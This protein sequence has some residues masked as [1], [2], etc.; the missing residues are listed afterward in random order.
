L[1]G[2]VPE[3]VMEPLHAGA[4]LAR[5]VALH[6]AKLLLQSAEA[7][8]TARPLGPV[9]ALAPL[10]FLGA[11]AG[12]GLQRGQPLLQRPQAGRQAF[13]HAPEVRARGL[14]RRR[15]SRLVPLQLE[16]RV[17]EGAL[18]GGGAIGGGLG[19]A[20]QRTE[21][22]VRPPPGAKPLPEAHVGRATRA[23]TERAWVT[24]VRT[25]EATVPTSRGPTAV[26]VGRSSTRPRTRSVTG[27]RPPASGSRE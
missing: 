26:P 23:S 2:V 13:P 12:L 8:V 17:G 4:Q 19:A 11:P 25:I 5:E 18:D 3:H 7:G 16:T 14:E 6:G 21:P 9:L 10:L 1:L 24:A 27:S 15:G 20:L 22:L